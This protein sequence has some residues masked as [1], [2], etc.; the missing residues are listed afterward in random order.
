MV[1]KY[2]NQNGNHNQKDRITDRGFARTGSHYRILSVENK[3]LRVFSPQAVSM[4]IAVRDPTAFAGISISHCGRTTMLICTGCDLLT[5]GDATNGDVLIRDFTR[6]AGS[7]HNHRGF[8]CGQ[9]FHFRSPYF[10]LM[11]CNML[12]C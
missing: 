3:S 6:L 11:A 7:P 5:G 12:H 9:F 2:R 4:L 1:T 10:G 8:K